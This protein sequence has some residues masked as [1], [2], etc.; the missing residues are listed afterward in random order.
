M[1]LGLVLVAQILRVYYCMRHV[2][3]TQRQERTT[4]YERQMVVVVPDGTPDAEIEAEV[5]WL[6][7]A[8]DDQS[9]SWEVVDEDTE[10]TEQVVECEA[11]E[12]DV[13]GLMVLYF[14]RRGVET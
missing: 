5:D 8:A 4:Y 14:H 11:H 6:E 13:D 3:V 10:T 2:L 1:I 7:Y 9:V 12:A